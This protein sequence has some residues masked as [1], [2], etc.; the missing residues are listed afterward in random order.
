MIVAEAL[1]NLVREPRTFWKAA[2]LARRTDLT[3][4]LDERRRRGLPVVVL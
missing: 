3:A 1:P 2:G 4:E